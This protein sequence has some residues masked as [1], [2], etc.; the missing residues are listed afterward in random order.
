MEDSELVMVDQK[1]DR[2]GA[3]GW[4]SIVLF[5]LVTLLIL[6]GCGNAGGT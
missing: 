4:F 5:G 3:V 1:R 6:S 2:K